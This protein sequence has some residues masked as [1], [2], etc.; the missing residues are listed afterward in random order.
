MNFWHLRGDK[1]LTDAIVLPILKTF[2]FGASV[3]GGR[4]HT[5][6]VADFGTNSGLFFGLEL[7]LNFSFPPYDISL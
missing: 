7:N 2:L 4:S 1:D 5:L 3:D 6:N